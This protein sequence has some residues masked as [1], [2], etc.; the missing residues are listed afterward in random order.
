MLGSISSLQWLPK[1]KLVEQATDLAGISPIPV[2]VG[3]HPGE[4]S[5]P[6]FP[7]AQ[8]RSN[9]LQ[10]TERETGRTSNPTGAGNQRY[11]Q[12]LMK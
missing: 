2:S 3:R 8:I 1:C 10:S 9:S 6:C 12:L 4:V 5:A 11:M 7:P